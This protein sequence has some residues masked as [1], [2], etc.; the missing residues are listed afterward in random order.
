[1]INLLWGVRGYYYDSMVSTDQ[2]FADLEQFLVHN[3]LLKSGDVFIS[4][5]SMPIHAKQ[6]TNMLKINVVS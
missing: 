2:T 4:L 6:R 1:T 3:K 5:A